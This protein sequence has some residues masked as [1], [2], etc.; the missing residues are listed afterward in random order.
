MP[1]MTEA[2]KLY[3]EALL[4][5]LENGYRRMLSLKPMPDVVED[6][7][8]QHRPYG[9]R[10]CTRMRLGPKYCDVCVRDRRDFGAT[11]V[12]SEPPSE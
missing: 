4:V 8:C 7:R 6:Q 10:Q 3:H 11:E 9:L 1:E 5:S 2:E 12:E